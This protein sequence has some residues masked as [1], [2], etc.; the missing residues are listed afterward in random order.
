MN[1]EQNRMKPSSDDRATVRS[2][3]SFVAVSTRTLDTDE[4]L[5]SAKPPNGTRDCSWLTYRSTYPWGPCAGT[6]PIPSGMPSNKVPKASSPELM[7]GVNVTPATAPVDATN[8]SLA[9]THRVAWGS[10]G[11]EPA[12]PNAGPGTA[13]AT[14]VIATATRTGRDAMRVILT[15]RPPI[16]GSA[17]ATVQRCPLWCASAPFGT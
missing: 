4:S 3:I 2:R 15:V 6:T 17:R 7:S 13:M 16:G 1:D 14:A 8:G 10:T 9:V 12:A 11:P 5:K